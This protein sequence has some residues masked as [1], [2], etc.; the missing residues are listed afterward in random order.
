MIPIYYTNT[1]LV[2]HLFENG[3][4]HHRRGHTFRSGC[5]CVD[6][7]YYEIKCLVSPASCKTC[8][9]I[10]TQEEVCILKELYQD[11]ALPIQGK[12]KFSCEH[13]IIEESK[14]YFTKEIMP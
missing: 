10:D 11:A 13:D 4:C 6:P 14:N 2:K 7:D 12:V 9:Y 5:E 1:T 8:D 3:H